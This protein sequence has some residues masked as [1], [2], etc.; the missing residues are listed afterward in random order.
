MHGLSRQVA[1]IERC[2]HFIDRFDY[3]QTLL[4]SRLLFSLFG[5]RR[6]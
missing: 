4:Q 5:A 2:N 3:I 1:F 6:A